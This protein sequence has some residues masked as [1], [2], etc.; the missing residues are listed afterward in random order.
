MRY[1]RVC[2]LFAIILAGFFSPFSQ[3]YIYITY[4][5]PLEW[6]YSE[7]RD[8]GERGFYFSDYPLTNSFTFRLDGTPDTQYPVITALDDPTK[9]S[10]YASFGDLP[11]PT[12]MTTVSGS[13]TM[14]GSTDVP[15]WEFTVNLVL[16]QNMYGTFTSEG[17]EGTCQCDHGVLYVDRYQPRSWMTPFS[18]AAYFSRQNGS[19]N[20]DTF[21]ADYETSNVSEP[22]IAYLLITGL[23]A[24]FMRR[25][26]L[27]ARVTG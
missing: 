7:N 6:E 18:L 22:G 5:N 26:A 1:L 17:G 2:S 25:R 27:H 20:W 4:S 15:R 11:V 3:A 13:L 23:A 12:S 16:S 14:L 19:G 24:L 10:F 9:A 8:T 21:F